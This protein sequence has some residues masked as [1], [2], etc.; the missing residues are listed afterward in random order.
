MLKVNGRSTKPFIRSVFDEAGK[1]WGKGGMS[2]ARDM[3]L[4]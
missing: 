2:Q 3:V 4:A 1:K